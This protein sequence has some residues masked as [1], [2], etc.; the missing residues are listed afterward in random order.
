[1][2]SALQPGPWIDG[3]SH[4]SSPK[5]DSDRDQFYQNA[6]EAGIC[7]FI[8]GGVEPGDWERQ[9]K[10]KKQYPDRLGS[11]FGLHPEWISSVGEEEAEKALNLLPQYL[12]KALALGEC[13]LDFRPFIV[14]DSFDLQ[15]EYFQLQLEM[16][17][18]LKKPV[19]L[20]IVQAFE[21][22]LKILDFESLP[23]KG[24]LHGFN[25][26]AHKA[27][28]YVERGWAISVGAS[29][30]RSD[31]ERLRQAVKEIPFEYLIIETDSP[32]QPPPDLMG[33]INPFTTLIRVAEE[34]ARIR[35]SSFSEV[36]DISKENLKRILG[37][38][39]SPN[40]KF[41]S[42]DRV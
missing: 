19:V 13:G 18:F 9:L 21:E 1:M 34:V 12:P 4:W 32:D 15:M 6:L 3:H 28:A 40:G 16:A 25:G 10:L 17:G 8:Q 7:Y 37:I 29:L 14:K 27:K 2:S 38:Q 26:S 5:L 23:R 24:Y 41:D 30:L 20:H 39:E 42:T 35:Q 33:K 22:S 11:C 36:L 31:N